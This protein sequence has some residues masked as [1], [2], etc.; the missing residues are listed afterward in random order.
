MFNSPLRCRST[1]L[2]VDDVQSGPPDLRASRLPGIAVRL[3]PRSRPQS[4]RS[5][6]QGLG[7][8]AHFALAFPVRVPRAGCRR[9]RPRS[10]CALRAGVPRA[11]FPCR[12]CGRAPA[13][14][15]AHNA[16]SC[17]S[18]SG[19]RPLRFPL[20][21]PPENSRRVC[22]GSPRQL[23]NPRAKN[24]SPRGGSFARASRTFSRLAP[25]PPHAHAPGGF[26]RR[27]QASPSA[28]SCRECRSCIAS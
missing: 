6:I 2:G 7:A 8:P 28:V 23:G 4:G 1:P 19:V 18:T 22:A 15:W 3:R 24:F 17:L 21:F 5:A 12:I 9:P 27:R 25:N 14:P 26:V 13:H 16:I 11:H 10:S 20:F